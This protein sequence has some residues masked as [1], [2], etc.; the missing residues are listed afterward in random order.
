MEFARQT[1]RAPRAKDKYG[2]SAPTDENIGVLA[3]FGSLLKLL[4][5]A[6]EP[7]EGEVLHASTQ[8]ALGT[9]PEG[10][11]HGDRI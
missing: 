7:F 2:G 3:G 6:S 4:H 1:G 10:V 9:K 11:D 8:K 5:T